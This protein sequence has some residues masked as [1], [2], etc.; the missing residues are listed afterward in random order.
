MTA[1]TPTV[2]RPP[3]KSQTCVFSKTFLIVDFFS[4]LPCL[5]HAFP[6]GFL[7]QPCT[8][9]CY[10]VYLCFLYFLFFLYFILFYFYFYFFTFGVHSS[11]FSGLDTFYEPL[12]TGE[13]VR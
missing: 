8:D 10:M 5:R 4:F 1:L 9:V 13:S 12:W 11:S 3:S 7:S 2:H 6:T